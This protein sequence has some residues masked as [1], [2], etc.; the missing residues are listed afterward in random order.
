MYKSSAA[1]D[2]NVQSLQLRQ[3][4]WSFA[5]FLVLLETADSF[6]G[7]VAALHSARIPVMLV[8]RF[9][10]RILT[11]IS[12]DSLRTSSDANYAIDAA[13]GGHLVVTSRHR[14]VTSLIVT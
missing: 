5:M 14:V 4:R 1:S 11:N 10:A 13:F 12:R 7:A 3:L 8:Y 9:V 2:L 6:V